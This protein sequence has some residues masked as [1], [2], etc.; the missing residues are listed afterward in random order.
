MKKIIAVLLLCALCLV[1]C[2]KKEEP[3]NNYKTDISSEALAEKVLS[4][5]NIAS[6]SKA[7]KAYIELQVEI[8]TS[9]CEEAIVYISSIGKADHFGI[10]KADSLENA[11]KILEQ[12]NQYLEKLEKSWMSDYSPEELPKLENAVT[13]QF[14]VYVTFI[15]LEDSARDASLKEIENMLKIN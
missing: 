7:D 9:V 10:F 8:E 3:T 13:K 15:I 12:S 1:G 11:E 4:C 2:S 6:L 5:A 14:G